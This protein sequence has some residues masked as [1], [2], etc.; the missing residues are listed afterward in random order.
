MQG[1]QAGRNAVFLRSCS[2]AGAWD[3]KGQGTAVMTREEDR[4]PDNLGTWEPP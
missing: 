3:M 4:G 2:W 1:S